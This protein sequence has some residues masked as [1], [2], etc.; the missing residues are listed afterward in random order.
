MYLSRSV[1]PIV[2]FKVTSCEESLFYL[3]ASAEDADIKPEKTDILWI[4]S[5]GP[6]YKAAPSMDYE[7]T[8]AF[9]LCTIGKYLGEKISPLDRLFVLYEPKFIKFAK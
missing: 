1:V 3:G 6:K 9:E 7:D 5:Y 4:G 2:R 8:I